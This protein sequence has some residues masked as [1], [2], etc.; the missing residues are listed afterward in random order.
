MKCPI[1]V[2]KGL[3]SKVYAGPTF[4][5]AMAGIAYYDEE[6]NYVY[7]DPNTR[8]TGFSCSNEHRFKVVEYQGQ[9]EFVYEE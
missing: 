9:K 4:V 8:T 6:G 7:E 1:C 3:K 5:T 2:K